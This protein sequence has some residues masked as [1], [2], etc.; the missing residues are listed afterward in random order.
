VVEDIFK[1][2]VNG[3]LRKGA[4]SFRITAGISS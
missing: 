1:I 2:Y 3:E 4:V